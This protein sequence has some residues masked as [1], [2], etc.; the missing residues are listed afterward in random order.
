M[1]PIPLLAC[2]AGLVAGVL[3]PAFFPGLRSSSQAGTALR[4]DLDEA[5]SRSDLVL[6]GTVVNG[7]SGETAKGEIYTDWTIDVERTF[8]GPSE[9][10]RTIRIPGGVLANGKGT[11]IPGMPRLALG[12]EVVLFLTEP[13]SEGIRVPVGLSQ[14]KYRIV[15]GSD[16]SRMAVQTG[17]HVTL[18]SARTTRS[19]DGFEMLDY[20]DL[21]ARI[22]AAS[23]KR[24]ALRFQE[25]F[26]PASPEAKGAGA[27]IDEKR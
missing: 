19:I 22:E 27:R 13:S 23:Q 10:Q 12:E 5:F 20:A 14:G 8:W 3:A 1:R 11:M 16:G 6:E 17:D 15:T 9:P 25:S 7:M 4:M 2:T 18:I 26:Q 21:V 24:V